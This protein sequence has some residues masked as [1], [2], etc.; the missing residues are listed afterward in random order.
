M[1]GPEDVEGGAVGHGGGDRHNLVVGVGE[2]DEAVREDLGESLLSGGLGFAGV[3]VIRA[4]AV[5]LLLLF[6]SGAEAATLLREGMKDD[7]LVLGLEELQ[8][9]DE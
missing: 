2:L 3:G 8:R 6:K 4:E 7:R 9:F 5:E 1:L